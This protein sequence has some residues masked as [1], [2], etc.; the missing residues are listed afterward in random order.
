MFCSHNYTHI[1]LLKSNIYRLLHVAM[2]EV[3]LR[4][5][6]V[7]DYLI[8]PDVSLTAGLLALLAFIKHDILLNN[9]CTP[10]IHDTLVV[11]NLCSAARVFFFRRR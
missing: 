8:A 5:G 2:G 3:L 6:E 7:P 1:Y 11:S 10:A 4:D 9:L